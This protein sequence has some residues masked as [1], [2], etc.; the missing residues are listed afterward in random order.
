[1]GFV[2]FEEVEMTKTEESLTDL[3]QVIIKDS[4]YAQILVLVDFPKMSH[5]NLSHRKLY[6]SIVRK[7]GFDDNFDLPKMLIHRINRFIDYFRFIE[8]L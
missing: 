5:R 8:N 2:G 3:D 6:L 7:F 4:F 1:M